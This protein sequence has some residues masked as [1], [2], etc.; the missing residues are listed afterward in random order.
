M[1]TNFSLYA[2]RLCNTHSTHKTLRGVY[3]K[4]GPNTRRNKSCCHVTPAPPAPYTVI[5]TDHG[6]GNG[7][8]P[9]QFHS[10]LAPYMVMVDRPLRER[11]SKCPV[12]QSRSVYSFDQPGCRA[13][14][15]ADTRRVGVTVQVITHRKHHQS[16]PWMKRCHRYAWMTA[17]F[18]V[19][20]RL[21]F[22]PGCWR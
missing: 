8:S 14:L 6:K 3:L 5:V 1:G 9:H 20:V 16:S 12:S 13:S 2:L 21:L 4:G 22:V 11:M 17:G 7:N 15:V 18:C 19:Q 10:L